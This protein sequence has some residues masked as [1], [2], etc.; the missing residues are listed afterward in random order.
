[1]RL[2][3]IDQQASVSN[4]HNNVLI[5]CKEQ[6]GLIIDLT[7]LSNENIQ[8]KNLEKFEKYQS[9]KIDLKQLWQVK[10]LVISV[11]F[12]ALDEIA[13][14]LPGWLAQIPGTVSKVDLQKI[15]LLETSRVLPCVL[16]LPM[17]W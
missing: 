7:E 6:T 5:D 4:Q 3:H 11:V 17:L 13:D 14:R 16:R 9:L 10:I 8:D 1:M 2:P 15:T 12:G